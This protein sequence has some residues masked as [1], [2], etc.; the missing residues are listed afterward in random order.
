MG[1]LSFKLFD[2]V[3]NEF[4]SPA[5]SALM[6]RLVEAEQLLAANT[7]NSLSGDLAMLVGPALGG[8]LIGMIGFSGVVLVDAVSFLISAILIFLIT[9][10]ANVAERVGQNAR[11]YMAIWVE[12]WQEWLAGLQLVKRERSISTLFTVMGIAMFGQGII[13]VLWAIFV[14]QVLKGGALEYGWVQV[15]VAAGGLLGAAFL[16]RVSKKLTS[17]QLIGISGL[18][19]GLLLLATFNLPSLP[20][21]LAIQFVNG[22]ASVGFFVPLETMLQNSVDDSYRG[23]I[24]GAYSTTNALL[25]LIG[26]GLASALGDRL[27]IVPVLNLSGGLY[28]LSGAA[29]LILLSQGKKAKYTAIVEQ[30][31]TPTG[32]H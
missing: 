23:R 11:A 16:G 20:I 8:I 17:G 13:L 26:Q 25:L 18:L 28:F 5:K 30:S 27:G 15:A 31:K 29:A 21:I 2:A 32:I 12:M 14:K 22:I 6:P 1:H 10:P 24:F 19:T 4:F 7:L 3:L 9:L